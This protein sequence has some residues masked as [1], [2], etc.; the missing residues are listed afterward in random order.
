[1][2]TAGV[3][4]Q[5]GAIIGLIVCI[6]VFAL[7]MGLTFPLLAFQLETLG[8]GNAMIGISAAMTPLGM[9]VAGPF[10]TW[11]IRRMSTVR[12]M[13][14]CILAMTVILFELPM[15]RE[16]YTWLVLRFLIG[17]CLA[18]LY[19]AGEVG[20]QKIVPEDSRGRIMGIYG[21]IM[22]LGTSSGPAILAVTGSHG[23][24]PFATGAVCL[25]IGAVA[26]LMVGKAIPEAC[27]TGDDRASVLSFAKAAPAL[28]AAF[29]AVA[30]FDHSVLSLLPLFGTEHGLAKSDAATLAAAAMVGAMIFQFPIGLLG[31]RFGVP[32]VQLVCALGVVAGCCLLPFVMSSALAAL[33]V[34]F[35]WGGAAFGIYTMASTELGQR[36]SGP[37]LVAGNVAISMMWGGGSL[38]GVPSAG[39][40]MDVMGANGLMIVIG[41]VFS[42]IA[43]L[44]AVKFLRSSTTRIAPQYA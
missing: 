26:L 23:F 25:G 40:A 21:A 3:N 33:A 22:M 29:A 41:A 1:M 44:Y 42:V 27:E 31:D 14:W 28:L 30:F 17:L 39:V 7:M 10:I 2:I 12:F 36:F 24:L 6:S 4:S 9:V 13:L 16:Y 20:L 19:T 34:T 38:V 37:M 8:Y 5:R 18:G 11:I 32:R 35:V 15:F 43:A